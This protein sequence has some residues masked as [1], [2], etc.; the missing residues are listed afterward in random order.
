VHEPAYWRCH[1][2]LAK[3]WGDWEPDLLPY[4]VQE[5]DG[6]MLVHGGVSTLWQCLIGS[7]TATAGQANTFFNAANAAIGVGDSATAAAATHTDL[8]ATSNKLRKQVDTGYPEHTAG[9]GSTNK[10]I[11]F[12]ATFDTTQANWSWQEAA[13]FNSPSL[14]SGR[15]LNRRVQDMGAKTNASSFQITFDISID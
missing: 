5:W 8:Q 15:M 6:N 4:D 13:V 1:I 2:T 11:R 12:R 7:G 3:F 9:T 10:T 14:G